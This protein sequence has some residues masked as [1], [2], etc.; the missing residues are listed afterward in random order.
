M[1]SSTLHDGP[2]S[3]VDAPT[4]RSFPEDSPFSHWA[5]PR[6]GRILLLYESL[7]YPSLTFGERANRRSLQC[8][9]RRRDANHPAHIAVNDI[10][11][12]ASRFGR[13]EE[14]RSLRGSR[15]GKL[16][17]E[18]RQ[19]RERARPSFSIS[20]V[21][22]RSA[23]ASTSARSSRSAAASRPRS[24]WPQTLAACANS[25]VIAVPPRSEVR[26]KQ[27]QT[28]SISSALA[29]SCI[30]GCACWRIGVGTSAILRIAT[31]RV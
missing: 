12:A 14:R 21:F 26:L 25:A 3:Q 9:S 27:A 30:S 23:A 7:G 29:K 8:F 24:R 28:T 16:Y 15:R 13:I 18:R 22:G 1:L 20:S 6:P 11:A 2:K 4:G 10:A 17:V 31:S 5:H 19:P